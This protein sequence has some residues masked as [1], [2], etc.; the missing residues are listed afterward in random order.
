MKITHLAKTKVNP[1]VD[2]YYFAQWDPVDIYFV[3][4]INKL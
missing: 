4:S 1:M 3:I 2:S